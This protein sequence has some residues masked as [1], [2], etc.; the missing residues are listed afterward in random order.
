MRVR[1]DIFLPCVQSWR[2]SG[3]VAVA[4]MSI[5]MIRSEVS[6]EV[7]SKV[8][9]ETGHTSTDSP[10]ESLLDFHR[11]TDHNEMT[12]KYATRARKVNHNAYKV[13]ICCIQS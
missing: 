8:S 3:A 4:Q 7:S 13:L 1:S 11:R 10:I 6:T 12:R 2:G 5:T 9:T